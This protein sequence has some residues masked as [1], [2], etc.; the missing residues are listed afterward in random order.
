MKNIDIT[1]VLVGTDPEAFVIDTKINKIVSAIGLIPGDKDHPFPISDEGHAIQT[2]NVMVEFCVPAA[3]DS[4]KLNEDIRYC[5]DIIDGKLPEGLKTVIQASAVLE[6]KYLDNEQAQKF[7]CDPDFNV[8][9]G[10]PNIAPNAKTNLRS[11]GGHIHVG[12]NNPD[13]EENEKIVKA[14]D[15]FLGIPS[16]VLDTDTERKKMYGKAGAYREKPY[17]IEYRVLSNFWI[18]N[19]ET[20]RWAFDQTMKAVMFVNNSIDGD[21]ISDDDQADIQ[22][23]I[24]NQDLDLACKIAKK[25]NILL[26][27]TERELV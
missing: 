26:T 1:Q 6:D 23:A 10:R 2:D 13:W 19:E 21:F 4:S 11:A 9:T 15:L 16:I 24:N 8:Y 14:M 25:Y 12:Y 3:N 27:F 5:L 22:L 17:G 7:G 18:K 20:V